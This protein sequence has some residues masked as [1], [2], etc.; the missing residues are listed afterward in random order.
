MG[1][2]ICVHAIPPLLRAV[3]VQQPLLKWVSSFH[4]LRDLLRVLKAVDGF[5]C[6][7]LQGLQ[8]CTRGRTPA[9]SCPLKTEEHGVPCLA[10]RD[11][12]LLRA[13]DLDLPDGERVEILDSEV[14]TTISRVKGEP[15]EV[16]IVAEYIYYFPVINMP[17]RTFSSLH[18]YLHVINHVS[19]LRVTNYVVSPGTVRR[20]PSSPSCSSVYHLHQLA[21]YSAT[22]A[23]CD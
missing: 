2:F 4:K 8:S 9:A 13:S 11:G 20:A 5:E 19:N 16:Y 7:K 12:L 17:L 15:S 10:D 21:V 3:L 22:I 14:E 23:P 1:H 18:G 6:F